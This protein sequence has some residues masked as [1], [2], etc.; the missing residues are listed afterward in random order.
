MVDDF[1]L[2]V[3]HSE[4]VR[5]LL[6]LKGCVSSAC[7][8]GNTSPALVITRCMN[9]SHGTLIEREE[10]IGSAASLS[11]CLCVCVYACVFMCICV[12]R[13]QISIMVGMSAEYGLIV[14]VCVHTDTAWRPC[15]LPSALWI[16]CEFSTADGLW[17]VC[18]RDFRLPAPLGQYWL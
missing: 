6:S 11:R 8:K 4:W 10:L 18:V 9:T 3:T 16:R 17:Q 12:S 5:G 1:L 15:C 2:S 13:C 14:C 7:F